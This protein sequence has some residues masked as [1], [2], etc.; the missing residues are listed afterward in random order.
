MIGALVELIVTLARVVVYCLHALALTIFPFLTPRKDISGKRVLV[1]GAGQGIGA[2]MA[3]IIA[4]KGANL[5]LWDV[6]SEGNEATAA[7]I[8]SSGGSASTYT[9]DLSDPAQIASTAQRVRTEVGPVDIVVNNAGIVVGKSFDKI[10]A[11]A[12]GKVMAVNANAVMWTTNEFLPQMLAREE[13]GHI[14]TIASAAGLFGGNK[15]ADYCASKFA[16]VG[17]MESLG[18]ELH[19][20]KGSADPSL[21]GAG[22]V[23][24]T[25]VCPYFIATGMFAGAGGRFPWLI[26]TLTPEFVAES[27]VDAML[28]NQDFILTPRI[29]WLFYFLKPLLPTKASLALSDFLGITTFM[30]NFS[31]HAA[32]AK[33]VD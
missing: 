18:I 14:V 22:N 23:K 9:V 11:A 10:S 33:K 16:A 32:A 17:F 15:L 26:R 12:V 5:V 8:V 6:N 21:I 28:K 7:S 31:G 19:G 29:L 1:T 27:V 30:D 24:T 13:G 3:K 2:L 20:A 25:V 4:A